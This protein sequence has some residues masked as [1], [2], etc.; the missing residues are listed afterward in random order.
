MLTTQQKRLMYQAGF[1]ILFA[2]APVFD[3]FRLDL[4]VK[5]FV[6]FGLDWKLGM[7]DLVAGRITMTEAIVNIILKG[8]LPIVAFVG[9]GIGVAWKYGRLYCGWLCPHFSVVETINGMLRRAIGKHSIWDKQKLP[10]RTPQGA[11]IA[12]DRRYWFLVVPLT[13]AFAF[14]WAT[15]LLTYLLPPFEIYGNLWHGTLT[16][17]Q[18][19]FLAAGTLAFAIEFMFARHLFCRFACAAGLFQSLAWMGNRKA[20]V[21]GFDGRRAKS[22][23]DCNAACDNACPMRLKPRNIKRFMFS[24]TQ[25]GQCIDACTHAQAGNPKGSL[26]KWVQDDCALGKSARDFGHH[27][28]VPDNCFAVKPVTLHP[29]KRPV[30]GLQNDAR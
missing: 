11:V 19:I 23:A 1:F 5:H 27:G 29:C 16:R 10:E 6:F 21:V 4:N 8:F 26:L 20:M 24:C 7:D 12:P 17:N 3:I 30:G 18:T 2:L 9:V 14:A 15:V 13:L 28:N 25:C 22:C